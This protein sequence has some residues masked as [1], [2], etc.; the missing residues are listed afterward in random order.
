V[1]R[2]LSFE[3]RYR[4]GRPRWDTGVT[5]PELRAFVEDEGRPPGRALDLGCGTGTN[6]VYLA[7]HRWDATGVDFVPRAIAFARRRAADAD[8]THGTRFLVGDVTRLP[9]LGDPFDLVLDIGCLHSIPKTSRT[10]YARSLLAT[11]RPGATYLLYA[12]SPPDRLGIGPGDLATLLSPALSLT[13][14]AEG[15]GRPSAWYRFTRR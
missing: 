4:L 3:L 11:M 5:P 8:I 6:V 13:S 14:F 12:F 9:R 10:G 2:R 7:R 1:L 15:S